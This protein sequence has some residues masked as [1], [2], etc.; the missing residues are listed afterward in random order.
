L[1]GFH[2]DGV[3]TPGIPNRWLEVPYVIR[4]EAR[5]LVFV[6][7]LEANKGLMDLLAIFEALA[8]EFPDLKLRIL[9]DGRLR[10]VLE[11]KLVRAG[12]SGRAS[13]LGA[14]P[15]EQVCQELRNA[16]LFVFPSHYESFG[17]VVLEAQAVG[18]PVVA[19]DIPAIREA[20]G[21]AAR[22][23][24]PEDTGPWIGAIR[25]LIRDQNRR[26]GMSVAGREHARRFTWRQVT[27]ELERYLYLAMSRGR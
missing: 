22:L 16:D 3:V 17:I 4:P 20:A 5:T 26:E 13:F 8:P 6:G 27:E 19:S 23:V 2:V 15:P 7:R 21:E 18:V 24:P 1:S 11:T 9:G 14:V 25:A 10:P 12:L